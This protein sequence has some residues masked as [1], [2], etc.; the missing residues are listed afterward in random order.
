MKP[1]HR[2]RSALGGLVLLGFTAPAL[3]ALLRWNDGKE[4]VYLVLNSALGWDSNLFASADAKSDTLFTASAGADYERRAGMIGVNASA[5]AEVG[6]F[7]EYTGENYVN[8]RASVELFKNSGRTTGNIRL[9]IAK[10]SRAD[11]AANI[12]AES[13]NTDAAV[14]V[15]YP[16][17]RRYSIAGSLG[18][19][20][21][22]FTDNALLVDLTTYTAA[23]DLLYARDSKH[24]LFA[25]YRLRLTDSQLG[26]SSYDHAFT[27]GITGRIAPKFN[28]TVRV[29]YQFRDTSG[30]VRNEDFSGLNA[31][32]A[33]TWTLTR[34]LNMTAQVSKDFATTSTD[35]SND[36]F[37]S[38]LEA[39]M[40]INARLS[41]FGG[42]AYGINDFLGSR[43]AG[44]RDEF[45]TI[46]AGGK[47]TLNEKVSL[48]LTASHL[49]NSS[50]VS[51]ADYDR[52]S[53]VLGLNCRF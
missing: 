51:I 23:A 7:F 25:G 18:Y 17:I 49:E 39:R 36:S 52:D 24:D 43:G 9:G 42:L 34:R 13:W 6:R 12:R 27:V 1:L 29:G 2:L 14:Q 15:R 47:Y 26:T 28:G 31:G 11:V 10:E 19:N 45:T 5:G 8:P 21:Q 20:F 22:D 37:I 30:P 44:R 41:V 3:M 46:S 35:I 53:V 33:V 40:G 38:A 48:S 50:N 16:V 32:I 4:E